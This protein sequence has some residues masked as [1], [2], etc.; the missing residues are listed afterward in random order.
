[1][2]ENN[3]LR[4]LKVGDEVLILKRKNEQPVAMPVTKVGRKYLYVG[5]TWGRLAF[6]LDNG[7]EQ[8][9]YGYRAQA[10]TS[11]G[12]EEFAHRR[13]IERILRGWE[14]RLPFESFRTTTLAEILGAIQREVEE[15]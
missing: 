8:T 4:S 5:P 7:M 3:N 2:L 13:S 9:D 12:W 1:M 11:E 15:R 6:D 10:L 14:V